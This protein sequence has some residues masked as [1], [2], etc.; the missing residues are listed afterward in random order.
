MTNYL[1]VHFLLLPLSAAEPAKSLSK[2]NLQKHLNGLFIE[3]VTLR[4]FI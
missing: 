3:Q 1:I 4:L 2:E